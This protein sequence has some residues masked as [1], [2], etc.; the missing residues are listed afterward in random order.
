VAPVRELL[1]VDHLH[2]VIDAVLRHVA[3]TSASLIMPTRRSSCTA[4]CP[5]IWYCSISLSTSTTLATTSTHAGL[6]L[7]QF[8]GRHDGRVVSFSDALHDDVA[9]GDDSVQAIVV[10]SR[11]AAHRLRDRASAVS[12]PTD[13]GFD[14]YR[15]RRDASR[16]RPWS[17]RFSQGSRPR[18]RR[19]RRMLNH[20]LSADPDY[21][22]AA[23]AGVARTLPS[24]R[25]RRS[26]TNHW[27]RDHS[28]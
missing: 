10:T 12:Q 4:R 7:R 25:Q 9:V 8:L 18:D 1:G 14:Q 20:R 24:R 15:C 6:P 23:R 13:S 21:R 11:P 2:E 28:R 19:P 27:V 3:A 16:P 26:S 22:S 17:S 5:R